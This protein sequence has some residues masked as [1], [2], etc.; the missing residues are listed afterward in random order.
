MHGKPAH[1]VRATV[2]TILKAVGAGISPGSMFRVLAAVNASR[3]RGGSTS[4]NKG[5][6]AVELYELRATVFDVDRQDWR[7]KFAKVISPERTVVGRDESLLRG[8]SSS[9]FEELAERV[10]FRKRCPMLRR[11]RGRSLPAIGSR[12]RRRR[13][14][15]FRHLVLDVTRVAHPGRCV[16]D[17]Q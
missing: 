8:P 9:T 15:L 6:M 5:S 10:A 1:R 14:C 4:A 17:L 16:Q 7:D 2:L 12:R 3:P 13:T 11:M